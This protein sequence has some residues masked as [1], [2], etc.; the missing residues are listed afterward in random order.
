[1]ESLRWRDGPQCQLEQPR[2]SA[3][4]FRI[5]FQR[6]HN[7]RRRDD[8]ACTVPDHDDFIGV[9]RPSGCNEA[10]RTDSDD[11]IERA[12]PAAREFPQDRPAAWDVDRSPAS[13]RLER[14]E[15]RERGRRSCS[16]AG[17][18]G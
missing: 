9:I 13:N 6:A 2:S 11:L 10:L 14:A 18:P 5:A 8:A 17:G 12:H 7:R 4:E 1:M 3:T 16:H 15:T